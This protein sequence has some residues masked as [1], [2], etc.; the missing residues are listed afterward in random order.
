MKQLHLAN[1]HRSLGAQFIEF[2][3]WEMP[4]SYTSLA[5]EHLAV[6]EAVGLFDI[7]HMGEFTVKGSGA[8]NFLQHVATNDVSRLVIGGSQY[9]T[10]TNERGGTKDD[11]VVYC[12][13]ENDFMIVC[14][15]SNVEKIGKWLVEQKYPGVEIE[16]I[17]TTTTLFA[18]QGPKAQLTL[19]RLTGFDLAQIKRFNIASID[20]AGIRTLV[21]RSGYTGED[22]FELFI[23][24]ETV[25]NPARA[26]KLWKALLKAGEGWGIKPCGL[27]ARD[28][29]RLEA[30]LCLYGNEL[31]E[32]ITPLEARIEFAVKF[33][34]GDFV[35]RDALLKQKSSCLKR[36]RI[37][38]R[39]LEAGIPRQ[40]YEIFRDE[41][42]IGSVTSGTFSPLLKVSI[43][44]G[45]VVPDVKD[46]ENLSVEI[47]GKK[48]AAKVVEWPF[49]D[50]KI[51]GRERK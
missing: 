6:R 30:G 38:L 20:V 29:T 49:Y 14:N 4:L 28:T 25:F 41:I 34:K 27:G 37:G 44:M 7:S 15:A 24:G 13:G 51:Y 32:D 8:L 18:L 5:E 16:D 17:T 19:Q 12:M 23:M 48:R 33:D 21:S 40:G 11:V 43:A 50:S 26:E 22:G 42:R 2:A 39:M 46:G 45:Y 3:G 35:G 9:S 31:T 1:V 36:I 10:V 47:H